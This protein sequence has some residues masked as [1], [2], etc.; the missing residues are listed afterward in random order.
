MG[1]IDTMAGTVAIAAGP[2]YTAISTVASGDSLTVRD[3]PDSASAFIHALSFKGAHVGGVRVRSPRMHDSSEGISVRSGDL[4][5]TLLLPEYMAQPLYKADPLIV[6]LIG[7]AADVDGGAVHLYYTDLPGSSARLFSP[8]DIR[9][10]VKNIKAFPTA[11]TNSATVGAWTDTKITTTSDQLHAD[12]DYAVLGIATD[13]AMLAMGVKGQ[14]T[15]NLRNTTDAGT[16]G[17]DTT[18][19]YV[20]LATKLQLPCIPVFNANNK[21]SYFISTVDT[22]A[23]S[24]ANVTLVLAELSSRL[25]AAP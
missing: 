24:T 12:A 14:E 11:V 25:P 15:G 8:G 23:S 1:A 9:P 5:S 2:V 10:L 13:V 6:E 3:F 22:V 21:G 19:Y 7:T 20:D 17:L 18:Q 4:A 16:I